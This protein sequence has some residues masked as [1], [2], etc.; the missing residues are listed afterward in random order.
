MGTSTPTDPA[1][2]TLARN[3]HHSSWPSLATDCCYLPLRVGNRSVV[4]CSDEVRSEAGTEEGGAGHGQTQERRSQ[5]R[6]ERH[7][8][9]VQEVMAEWGFTDE[10]SAEVGR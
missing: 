6:E 2:E 1:I 7:R 8:I 9:R 3:H 5:L 10:A 4:D